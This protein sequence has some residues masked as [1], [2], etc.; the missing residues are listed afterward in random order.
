MIEPLTGLSGYVGVAL[1]AALIIFTAHQIRLGRLRSIVDELPRQLEGATLYCSEQLLV[2]EEPLALR[3]RVDQV[4][5]RPDK[6][7]VIAD[8]K[9]REIVRYYMSDRIQLTGYAFLLKYHAATKERSIA[10]YGFLRIPQ[11]GKAV[12]LK[13]PLLSEAEYR[14][15]YNHYRQ[16]MQSSARPRP[17]TS[18]L[19]CRG[20]GHLGRCPIPL[21]NRQ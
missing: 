1:V 20:C 12:Y 10:P 16:L 13:V 21:I 11:G 3:G 6:Q 19:I 8:T 15:S 7:L 2:I 4:W 9:T 17:A 5:E 18:P 14:D